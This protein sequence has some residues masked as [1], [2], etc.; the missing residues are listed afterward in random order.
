MN[1]FLRVVKDKISE[2]VSVYL[3]ST[4]TKIGEICKIIIQEILK[5]F[6]Y[7]LYTGSE[8]SGYFWETNFDENFC[9]REEFKK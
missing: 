7:H 1:T 2:E 3:I 5:D 4:K 9:T 8:I 6:G